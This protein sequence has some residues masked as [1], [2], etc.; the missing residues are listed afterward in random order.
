MHE[1]YLEYQ[2]SHLSVKEIINGLGD[3]ISYL[4]LRESEKP[5]SRT[6]LA[7]VIIQKTLI[8]TR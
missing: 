1:L 3:L 7:V 4:E 5:L 2:A 8:H 6:K